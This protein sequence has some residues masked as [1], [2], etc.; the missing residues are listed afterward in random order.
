MLTGANVYYGNTTISAGTLQLGIGGATGSI[1]SGTN[2]LNT[3][4]NNGTLILDNSGELDAR[5]QS[6]R[7]RCHDRERQS[8]RLRGLGDVEGTEHL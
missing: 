8:Y 3:I 1:T 4:T 6:E 7:H 2:N 5:R